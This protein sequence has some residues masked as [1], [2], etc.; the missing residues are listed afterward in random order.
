MLFQNF[1]A[2]KA[3]IL[4]SNAFLS[5]LVGS[6]LFTS[7]HANASDEIVNI[8][9]QTTFDV[10]FGGLSVGVMSFKIAS[11]QKTYTLTGGGRTKGLAAW[12]SSGKASLKSAGTL[13]PTFANAQNYSI[14]ISDQKKTATLKM[15]LNNGSLKNIAMKPDKT[16]KHLGANYVTIK[17]SD[18]FGIIDPASTLV[19]P[20]PYEKASDPKHVCNQLHR[21]YDGETRYD[22]KLSY[23]K[24][25]PIKTNGYSGHAYVCR[26]KY[27]PVSGHK[28]TNKNA[29]RMAANNDMEI[30]LAPMQASNIFTP[31]RIRVPTW[32]GNFYADPTYFGPAK[33]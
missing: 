22:M 10:R 31:I 29:K 20:V 25:A 1:N 2:N 23:K 4:S 19:I 18:L 32:I 7:K 11:D 12:F 27:I 15:A 6:Y 28:T 30:W 26:L 16:K 21:V 5:V 24:N 14:S 3:A 33:S 9:H 13:E 17:D 8:N